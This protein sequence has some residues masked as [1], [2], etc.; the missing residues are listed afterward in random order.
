VASFLTKNLTTI[1][2]RWPLAAQ[3][4][5]AAPPEPRAELVQNGPQQTLLVD[6]I[7]LTSSYDRQ[8][9]AVVQASLIPQDSCEAW[10]YGIGLGDLPRELLRRPQLRR[11]HV[12]LI[13]PSVARQSFE[14]FDHQD[15]LLDERVEILTASGQSHVR[16]PFA[17][18]PSCLQLADNDS[19]RLRDLVVLELATPF[20]HKR[21]TADNPEL[22]ARLRENEPYVAADADVA[23]LFGRYPGATILVAAAGPTLSE[24]YEKLRNRKSPLIA[25]D[26]AL[27]PLTQAGVVPDVVV[28]ID[29]LVEA[30]GPF[31]READLSACDNRT[32]VYF[33]S[34]PLGVLHTWPGKRFVAYSNAIM[35]RDVRRRLPRAALFSAGSV[36]HPAV[37]LAVRMGASQVVL[38]GAD[39]AYPGG[40]SHVAGSIFARDIDRGMAGDWVLDGNG[41]R[42]PTAPN[43]LGYLRDLESYIS[44]NRQVAF[45]NTHAGGARIQGAPLLKD[46]ENDF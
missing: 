35:Y 22:Q 28:S 5:A 26:A 34:S 41:Q 33:P 38:F 25:V 24:H 31:F 9:E 12:V 7:H 17:A 11:V 32:L 45:R 14:F 20:I 2:H 39:F 43:F 3:A 23:E 8:A 27:K 13:N 44:K 36:I 29:F 15:W 46:L 10:V 21:H 30:I 19:A 16:L 4:L 6:G 18:V 42:I 37:D 1:Q 40:R